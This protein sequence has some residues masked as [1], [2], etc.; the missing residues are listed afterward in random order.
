ME[1]ELSELLRDPQR[2]AEIPR[3]A[4]PYVLGQVEQ[5]RAALW[6]RML[7]GEESRENRHESQSQGDRLLPAAEAAILLGVSIKWLYRHSK[8]LPFARQ[9]SRRV[10]RFSEVG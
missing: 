10:L 2:V 1:F 9:L 7:H 8:R 5:L 4:I 3:Q 6:M